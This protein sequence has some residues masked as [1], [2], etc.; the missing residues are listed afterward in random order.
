MVGIDSSKSQS[1][2]VFLFFDLEVA[3]HHIEYISHLIKYRVQN[4][5]AGKFIFLIHHLAIDRLA[6]FNLPANWSNAV[7]IEHP[8]EKEQQILDKTKSKVQKASKELKI[9]KR[10]GEKHQINTCCL[11]FLNK[12][13]LALG[14]RIGKSLPGNIRGILFNPLGRSGKLLNDFLLSPRKKIQISWMLRNEKIDRIFLLNDKEKAIELNDH[15]RKKKL[16]NS[17]PDP[18]LPLPSPQVD[19]ANATEDEED[20]RIKFLLFGALSERKGIFTVLDALQ[21]LPPSVSSHIE[22]IFAGKLGKK[23]RESFICQLKHIKEN[24]SELELILID[25]FLTNAETA[26]L[27][28]RADFILAPYIGSEASSGI[29]GHAAFYKKPVI[30]PGRGLIG[31]LIKDY[32]LGLTIEPMNE[33]Q[34]CSAIV[35]ASNRE[36]KL[37]TEGME[38][39]VKERQPDEFAKFLTD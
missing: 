14:G 9:V 20:G 18:V 22:V 27:F 37:N 10:T 32:N 33:E 29:I 19:P 23:N 30:G 8:S 13:Q 4:A 25:H 15:Y 17:L 1:H 24:N 35:K 34:L 3:G 21:V 5:S 7:V 16:F 12:Y 28:I 36:I 6:D 38:L 11:M 31:K 26:K 39:F 2:S